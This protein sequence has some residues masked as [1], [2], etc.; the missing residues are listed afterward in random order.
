MNKI[1]KLL[2]LLLFFFLFV[3]NILAEEH[4]L[5]L[6]LFYGK[7]CPHCANL[8]KFLES[9]LKEKPNLKLYKYEVWHDDENMK[10]CIEVGKVLKKSADSIPYLVIGK[11]VV[12]GFDEEITPEKIKSIVNYYSNIKFKDK[13]GIYLGIV[14]DDGLEDTSKEWVDDEVNIPLLGKKKINEAPILL[15]SI[16]IGLV[17]GFNPC[18]MWILLFL[19]S[20][21]IGMENK[22]RRLALGITFL[23]SSAIVYLLFLLAWLEFAIFAES[24]TYIRIAIAFIAIIFGTVTVL[25]FFTKKQDDGCEV[26]N[27][28]NRRRI[29]NAIRKII[30]EKSFVFALLGISLLAISVNIIELLCSLGLPYVFGEILAIN[31]I[32][33]AS[34]LMYSLIYVFFFLIDDIIIFVIAMKT[35]EIKAISNRYAKYV[36]LLGGI[37]MLAIG[38]LMIYK[39]S[40]LMFNF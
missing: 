8:E 29:I 11:S 35:L 16:I 38:I 22:K 27:I 3:P 19:I 34:R 7:E 39:P 17:D 24:I 40:W 9:Y 6:Y 32:G 18:A 4:D 30:G 15:S 2:F 36:H 13:A 14:E 26:V 10:K 1:K 23:L 28:N 33:F 20:M 25:K 5:N 37:I 31:K 12:S 21:L